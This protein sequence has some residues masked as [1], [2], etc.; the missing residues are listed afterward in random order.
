MSQ[1]FCHICVVIITYTSNSQCCVFKKAIYVL[2][3]VCL[4]GVQEAWQLVHSAFSNLAVKLH[5][6]SGGFL[7]NI[8]HMK[9]VTASWRVRNVTLCGRGNICIDFSFA[10]PCFHVLHEMVIPLFI[11]FLLFNVLFCIAIWIFIYCLWDYFICY[12]CYYICLQYI[13]VVHKRVEKFCFYTQC[14]ACL[15]GLEGLKLREP[16][17]FC[18][19]ARIHIHIRKW[20]CTDPEFHTAVNQ[21]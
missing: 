5:L 21:D 16:T 2:R 3:K 9:V 19:C 1:L 8:Y 17:F 6:I 4:Y 10:L 13:S 18:P 7:C 12:I 15:Q 11:Y 14:S 20:T